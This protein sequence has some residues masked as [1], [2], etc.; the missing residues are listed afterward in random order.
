MYVKTILTPLFFGVIGF[1]AAQ[2]FEVCFPDKG[3]PSVS[4]LGGTVASVA[5]TMLGFMLASLAVLASINH[6]HL[7]GM[8]K[9]TGHYSDLLFTMFLGCFFEFTVFLLGI[10]LLLLPTDNV[11]FIRLL[12]A[13]HLCAFITMLDIGRKFWFVM[14]NLRN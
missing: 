6:T 14:T 4:G 13:L 5:S 7:V 1:F 11:F 10:F 8:M 12:V 2:Y 9:K 3:L